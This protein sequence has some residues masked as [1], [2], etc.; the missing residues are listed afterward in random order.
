VDRESLK[1]EIQSN[2]DK[3][4]DLILSLIYRVEVLEKENLELRARLNKNSTNS[5]KPPSSDGF[6]KS[7]SNFNS[8]KKSDK[9]SGG[10][11]NHQGTTLKMSSNPDTIHSCYPEKCLNCLKLTEC[12]SK[13]DY[14]K[15]QV[16]DIERPVVSV[17]EY[18]S[19]FGTC[20]SDGQSVRAKFPDSIKSPVSYGPSL[21]SL[22]VLIKN[23]QLIPYERLCEF[24]KD[25]YG[26]EISQGTIANI[27]KQV[28][29]NLDK[30][31]NGLRDYA[32]NAAILNSDETG[33]RVKK[34]LHWL[35]VYSNEFF[36][37]YARHKKR[38]KEGMN[39]IAI[40]AYFNGVLCHDFWKS[41][42]DNN[43]KHAMCNAHILRELRAMSEL[44]NEKWSEGL[45]NILLEIKKRVD[46]TPEKKLSQKLYTR[47]RNRYLEHIQEAMKLHPS[48]KRVPGKRGLI[49]KGKALSLLERL[50]KHADDI[51]RFAKESAT[52][53]D[54]NQA[55]RDLRM[56]KTKQKISGCFRS[57]NGAD[58]FCKIRS[59]I[60]T[61]KKQKMNVL[62]AIEVA[63]S[64][65]P[66]FLPE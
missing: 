48:P 30:Y 16:F 2:P 23:Y 65:T 28:S 29:N 15:R 41:Y 50:L 55:E 54:N 3:I 36:T 63:V 37:F 21:R 34:A 49:K 66:R 45:M 62:E 7:S 39:V 58:Y 10:Q 14:H 27:E 32:R 24:L 18:R 12:K 57:E 31:Y 13:F 1:F 44:Y 19:Y 9:K 5:S 20:C 61:V 26:I 47:Y 59:Y 25:F 17:T 64:G 60:A 8:R 52:P 46:K 4:A 42:F 35:H 6:H 53:F 22:I 38:G 40:L 33:L 56:M 11:N 43:C 51:L